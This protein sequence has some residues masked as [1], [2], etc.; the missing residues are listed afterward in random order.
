MA[1]PHV[2]GAAALLRQL[3]PEWTVSDIHSTL[4]LTANSQH[5]LKEM[6]VHPP[7]HLMW[8]QG[9]SCG[10]SRKAGLSLRESIDGFRLANPQKA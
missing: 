10:F 7:T 1:S 2:A 3:H 4:S 6:A 8:V 5:A 9:L